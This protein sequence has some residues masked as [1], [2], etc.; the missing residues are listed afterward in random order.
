[1]VATL[2]YRFC[3]A[4]YCTFWLIY[5][6]K[7]PVIFLNGVNISIFAFLTTWTYIV[8]TV[9]LVIHFVWT[10]LFAC[11]SEVGILSRLTVENHRRMFNELQVQPSLWANDDYEYVPENDGREELDNV[12]DVMAAPHTHQHWLA[13]LVWLLFN[14]ASLGCLLV[15]LIFWTMLYPYLPNMSGPSLML[16]FQLHAVTSIII[17]VEHCVTAIPIRLLHFVYALVYGLIYV[18]FS[19]VLYA[20][21]NKYVLYP[22]VL[23][24]RDPGRTVAVCCIAA[25][26]G[27]PLLHLIL[28]GFYSLKLKIFNRCYPEEL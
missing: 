26:I 10:L 12:T 15:T 18:A 14:I 4:V 27:L 13:K 17:I 7:N 1:M 9:Y 8:L 20:A 28:F 24:W 11:K 25:F 19:G 2:V 6:T 22:K 21:D 23:D 16:N 5:T 3:L